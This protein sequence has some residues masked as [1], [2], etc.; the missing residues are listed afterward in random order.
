MI[1]LVISALVDNPDKTMPPLVL[2]TMAQLVLTGGLTPV[3]NKPGLEQ[4]SYLAPARWGYAAVA[5]VT[6]LN[7][8]Q[9]LGDSRLNPGSVADPLWQHSATTYLTDVGGCLGV[10]VVAVVVTAL[11]LRRL[12]PKIVRRARKTPLRVGSRH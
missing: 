9:R 8:V 4:L 10:G 12:D 3:V 7:T 11:L 5:S 6:D 2:V 1:G